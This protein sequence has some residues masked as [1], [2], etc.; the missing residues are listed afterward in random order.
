MT[1]REKLSKRKTLILDAVV[2][3]GAGTDRQIMER[4]MLSEPN[5]VR[6]SITTLVQNGM[7]AEIGTTRCHVTGKKVRLV[8]LPEGCTV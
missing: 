5:M 2:S 7:L 4:V 8:D 3:A 1:M 6:P